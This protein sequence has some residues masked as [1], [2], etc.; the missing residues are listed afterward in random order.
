[1]EVVFFFKKAFVEI[2]IRHSEVELPEME[3]HAQ[4]GKS[5]VG[6]AQWRSYPA[7]VQK[8]RVRIPPENKFFLGKHSNAVT[9]KCWEKLLRTKLVNILFRSLLWFNIRSTLIN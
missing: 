9:Q 5:P 3:L 8:T 7:Q 1:M 4:L 6:V 2:D